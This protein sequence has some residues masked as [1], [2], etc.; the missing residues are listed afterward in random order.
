MR[1]E[2]QL[3]NILFSILTSRV[4]LNVSFRAFDTALSPKNLFIAKFQ[5]DLHSSLVFSSW[6]ISPTFASSTAWASLTQT[7]NF[8][9][10]A[11]LRILPEN[12]LLTLFSSRLIVSTRLVMPMTARPLLLTLARQLC[13]VSSRQ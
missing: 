3:T 5:R 9:G 13:A 1:S 4:I 6:S 11:V 12:L 2:N 8:P 7:P 10:G